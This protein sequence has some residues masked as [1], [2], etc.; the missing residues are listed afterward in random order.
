MHPPETEAYQEKSFSNYICRRQTGSSA[1][2]V[3]FCSR[4]DSMILS[5]RGAERDSF[6]INQHRDHQSA[7]FDSP[8]TRRIDG[9]S[10]DSS[11]PQ[12]SGPFDPP[13]CWHSSRLMMMNRS[14]AVEKTKPAAPD[15]SPEIWSSVFVD[16]LH[17]SLC[18]HFSLWLCCIVGNLGSG[19]WK[20]VHWSRITFP[21]H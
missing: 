20:A 5:L 6:Q 4:L 11:S 8:D 17:L 1:A 21:W 13:G 18:K 7:H 19:F 3:A 9:V 2:R 16:I 10:G 12:T 14:V 15:G